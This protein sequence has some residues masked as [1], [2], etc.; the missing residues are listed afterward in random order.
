MAV[1]G[2]LALISGRSIRDIDA[3]TGHVAPA[4]AGLHGL[5]I[6][7]TD[8]RQRTADHESPA[9]A[10]ARQHLQ[11]LVEKHPGL[12]LEDKKATLAL[13]YRSA[14]EKAAAEADRATDAIVNESDGALARLSGKSVYE[15]K[16]AH[17]DKGDALRALLESPPFAG[18]LPIYI[19]DDVTD[20]AGFAAANALGGMSI[21][22]GD[23]GDSAAH[24][25]LDTVDEVLEWLEQTTATLTR[26]SE[27]PI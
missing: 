21:R 24:N 18:R 5:E 1:G 8:G 7:T 25:Q 16:P 19:G 23:I 14:T 9:L 11:S 10:K 12:Y 20:E 17:G 26:K 3:M 2:A 4:A 27:P 6:R 13:H 15:L 22:V